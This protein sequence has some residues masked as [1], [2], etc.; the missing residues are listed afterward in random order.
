MVLAAARKMA[1][2]V[3]SVKVSV[4]VTATHPMTPAATPGSGGGAPVVVIHQHIAGTVV[5]DQQLQQHA[6]TQFLRYTHRNSGN[7]LYLQG[8]ASGAPVSR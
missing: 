4:P 2:A 1:A 6:Q 7:G 5:A 8:R 3:A